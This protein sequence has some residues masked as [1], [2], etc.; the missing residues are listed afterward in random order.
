MRLW[1]L[2]SLAAFDGGDASIAT[3]MHDRIGSPSSSL[4]SSTGTSRLTISAPASPSF[5]SPSAATM[6]SE[7]SRLTAIYA[8][9]AQ[10][11][12]E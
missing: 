6:F 12:D 5:E 9:T 7:A 8:S 10:I 2:D 11:S 1:Y 3:M 4:P